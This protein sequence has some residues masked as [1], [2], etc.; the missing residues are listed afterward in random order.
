MILLYSIGS[1]HVIIFEE[2][3]TIVEF[4]GTGILNIHNRDEKFIFHGV[5]MILNGE[6]NLFWKTDE[7]RFSRI[8]FIGRNL[9][10]A[11]LERAFLACLAKIT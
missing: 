10:A 9:N 2:S 7:I 1:S 5:H 6:R 3:L 11:E 8:V 4:H